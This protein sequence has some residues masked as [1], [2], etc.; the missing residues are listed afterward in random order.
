[1]SWTNQQM[2]ENVPLWFRNQFRSRKAFSKRDLKPG[3]EVMCYWDGA[4]YTISDYGPYVTAAGSAQRTMD[5]NHGISPAVLRKLNS[6]ADHGSPFY[7]EKFSVTEPTFADKMY[8]FGTPSGSWGHRWYE[9]TGPFYPSWLTHNEARRLHLMGESYTPEPD[10][11]FTPLSVWELQ[12]LGASA[13]TRA[14]PTLPDSEIATA[15]GELAQGFPSVPLRK[16]AKDP[17]LSSVGDEYLNFTFGI[18][19]TVKDVVELQKTSQEMANKIAQLKR[20]SGR[21]IRRRFEINKTEE[22]TTEVLPNQSSYPAE[23]MGTLTRKKTVSTRTWFSGAF[24]HSYPKDLD[25]QLQKFV[26]FNSTYG[27][28]PNGSTAWNLVPYSWLIDWFSNV[29]DVIQNVS[30]LGK[31]GLHIVYAYIMCETTVR[32]DD[33]LVGTHSGY[34]ISTSCSVVTTTKQRLRAT[35]F[36]FGVSPL[37]LTAKQG[38]ILTALGLSRS[39]S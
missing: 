18:E 35:P 38:A 31:D 20:D 23:W 30:Y 24:K 2:A 33:T 34:P 16:F 28:I 7:S 4:R 11:T 29:G 14:L 22:V 13:I 27:A 8:L 26:D 6:T 39:R 32:I 36:G 15:L 12:A 9:V 19:P 3:F 1:M 17:S 21:L 37:A 5:V 10:S 25:E